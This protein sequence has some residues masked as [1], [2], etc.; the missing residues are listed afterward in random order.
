MLE[1]HQ[2]AVAAQ[3]RAGVDH[4]AVGGGEHRIAGLAAED[5]A[6][7]A[8]LVEAARAPGR[9]PARPSSRRRRR[10]ACAGGVP[11][12]CRR[13]AAPAPARAAPRR[14][15]SARC[16]RRGRRA[17][18]RGIERPRLDP[19]GRRPARR[20]RAGV[21]ARRRR[22]A[23]PARPRAGSGCSRLFQR[24][25]SFQFCP[26]S[27]PIADQRVAGLDGVVAGLAGVLGHRRLGRLARRRRGRRRSP[28]RA[29]GGAVARGAAMRSSTGAR[30][31]V[32]ARSRRAASAARERGHAAAAAGAARPRSRAWIRLR[33]FIATARILGGRS[34]PPR[35]RCG[36]T[37]LG[38]RS[39]TTSTCRAAGLLDR[40]DQ[41]AADGELLEPGLR[42]L[43]AAGG[44]DDAVVGRARRMAAACRRRYTRRRRSSAA[45]PAARA[46]CRAAASAARPRPP[47]APAAPAAPPGSRSRCRS[48]ARAP[49]LAA[50]ARALAPPNS[51]SIMRA[52]TEGLEI[53]WPWPIGRLVSS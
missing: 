37:R 21:D 28:A 52:T 23:A 10:R 34:A 45:A 11:A 3:A 6:L 47:A 12:R 4:A 53:V 49:R 25:R 36:R 30:F 39:T 22:R 8:G 50:R 17:P 7:V 1:D 20:R 5:Q 32:R 51:S 24:T 40:R 2:V 48:R 9:R 14:R 44:G 33:C 26:F 31:G 46:P 15:P 13:T 42:Q 43:V 29:G 38:C 27:R 41:A 18:A 16:R 19:R 35:E